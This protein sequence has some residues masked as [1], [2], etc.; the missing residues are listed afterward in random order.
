MIR[1]LKKLKVMVILGTRPEA[2][3]LAPVILELRKCPETIPVVVATAQHREMLDQVL[4]LFEIR[5]DFDLNLMVPNQTLYHITEKAIKSFEGVLKEATPDFILVQGDTTTSFIGALAGFYGKIYVGHVEAGLRT[6]KKYY[7]FPEEINRKLVTVLSDYH[8]APTERNLQNLL[9]EGVPPDRI[10][11]TGNTVIDALFMTVRNGFNHKVLTSYDH[12]KLILITAHRREN[13][14]QPLK[15]ICISI[16]EMAQDNPRFL[17]LYPVHLNQNVQK[18]VNAVLSNIPNVKLLPP[19]DYYTFANIMA[20]ADLI[21]TDS[22]GIQEEAPS[23][24]KPVLVLRNETERPEAVEAGTVKI[25]GTE[26]EKIISDTL[27][28]LNN[29]AAYGDMARAHNPYG[30]GTAS[31]KIVNFI[32]L[33]FSK[34][35]S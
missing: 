30:D 11:V 1:T 6:R 12:D 29:P 9:S 25:V 24:G 27:Y 4:R 13:F 26:K 23:L 19:L 21:L 5:P 7:P 18:P 33:N 16:R 32:K 28:L 2:I 8:F 20:K 35:S 10:V 17:F 14:G 31:E 22:G 3:K 15:D 34:L